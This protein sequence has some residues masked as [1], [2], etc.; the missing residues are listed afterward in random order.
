MSK[1]TELS[2]SRKK[3]KKDVGTPG[4]VKIMM[5]VR[6]F[7]GKKAGKPKWVRLPN[8]K[9]LELDLIKQWYIRMQKSRALKLVFIHGIQTCVR[10]CY[11]NK[12]PTWFNQKI[13]TATPEKTTKEYFNKALR[14]LMCMRLHE[15][16]GAGF[17][18]TDSSSKS[19]TKYSQLKFR[20]FSS[21]SSSCR[22]FG[23][24]PKT[25]FEIIKL[26]EDNIEKPTGKDTYPWQEKSNFTS[27]RYSNWDKTVAGWPD[28]NGEF[29]QVQVHCKE[30]TGV[31]KELFFMVLRGMPVDVLLYGGYTTVQQL[32]QQYKAHQKTTADKQEQEEKPDLMGGGGGGGYTSPSGSFQSGSHIEPHE[33]TPTSQEE[34]TTSKSTSAG[35]KSFWSRVGAKIGGGG[36]KKSASQGSTDPVS[37]T[38][39]SMMDFTQM[40]KQA[41]SEA[42]EADKASK[43]AEEIAKQARR[44]SFGRSNGRGW[45]SGVAPMIGYVRPY[46]VSAMESYTG[47]TPRMYGRHIDSAT[48]LPMG[49]AMAPLSRANSYYGS[50]RLGER[51]NPSFGRTARKTVKKTAARKTVKKTTARKTAARKTVKKTAAR[52]TV[53][54]NTARKTAARK[55]TARKTARKSGVSFGQGFF[56]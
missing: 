37:A 34:E 33:K 9:E 10:I 17:L 56:F 50:Y 55:T 13:T 36:S 15:P 40:S 26:L 14:I 39:G 8:M 6:D 47:M 21:L 27:G 3:S 53:K 49:G 42:G 24:E 43:K 28:E 52:N 1:S 19:A 25:I 5:C 12:I 31:M 44:G 45:S 2:F 48:G 46:R 29:R 30:V 38:S 18:L 22:Y 32:I 41:R 4:D 7:S 23:Q 16:S 35:G 11:A 20:N 54:K 51:L